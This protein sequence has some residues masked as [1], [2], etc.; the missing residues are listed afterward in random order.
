[1]AEKPAERRLER[2]EPARRLGAA[3]TRS[4]AAPP[5][6]NDNAPPLIARI[7]TASGFAILAAAVAGLIYIL[8]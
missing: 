1:M 6:A 8:A 7:A 2:P 5:P 3:V 4:H